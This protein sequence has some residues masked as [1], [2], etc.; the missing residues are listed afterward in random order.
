MSKNSKEANELL[1]NIGAEIVITKLV[2]LWLNKNHPQKQYSLII[3][4]AV[5]WLKK[6]LNEKG[7]DE[8]KLEI[9]EAI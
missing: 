5:S 4:K 7:I 8:T 9:I 6:A 1:N 2:I 3:K